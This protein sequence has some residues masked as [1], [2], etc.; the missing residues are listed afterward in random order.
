MNDDREY[1]YFGYFHPEEPLELVSIIRT[2]ES[3][4]FERWNET[5]GVW[6][7]LLNDSIGE[8]QIQLHDTR[9]EVSWV[10]ALFSQAFE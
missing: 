9:L 1:S 7:F 2:D 6:R 4:Y 8:T 5:L 3:G 10:K